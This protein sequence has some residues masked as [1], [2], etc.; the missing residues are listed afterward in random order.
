MGCSSNYYIPVSCFWQN[1]KF[2]EGITVKRN[3]ILWCGISSQVVAIFVAAED[4]F[5]LSALSAQSPAAKPAVA[6]SFLFSSQPTH[7]LFFWYW[8]SARW[9]WWRTVLA[10]LAIYRQIRDFGL[11]YGDGKLELAIHRQWRFWAPGIG[12]F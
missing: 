9:W 11:L 7:F 6:V 8:R 1:V 2:L 3:N 10:F 4:G 12:E 5:C